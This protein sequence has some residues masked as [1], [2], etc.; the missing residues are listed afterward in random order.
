VR[1]APA[2]ELQ[3]GAPRWYFPANIVLFLMVLAALLFT[4]VQMFWSLVVVTTALIIIWIDLRCAVRQRNPSVIKVYPDGSLSLLDAEYNEISI[5]YAG[6]CWINSKLIVLPIERVSGS[7]ER[8]LI[9]RD[10]NDDDAF[11]RFAVLCR[12]GFAV[13]SA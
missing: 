6:K 8:L 13:D 3:T 4:R 5:N 9:A 12:Y 11:R 2:L 7:R 1:P 10:L